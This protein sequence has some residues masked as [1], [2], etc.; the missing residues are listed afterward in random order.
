[1][2]KMNAT[3]A[4]AMA[5]LFMVGS[6]MAATPETEAGNEPYENEMAVTNSTVT[7]GAVEAQAAE[8][9]PAAGQADATPAAAA[10]PQ[11]TLTRQ[12][13]EREAA[14]QEP[15]AGQGPFESK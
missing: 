5:A 10:D 8:Q 15:A 4:A 12:A 7:R 9:K 13:V 6:A 1:M 3:I 2:I 14:M 11:S